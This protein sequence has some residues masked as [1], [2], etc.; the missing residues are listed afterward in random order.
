[1]KSTPMSFTPGTRTAKKEEQ[2]A[3]RAEGDISSLSASRRMQSIQALSEKS[4]GKDEWVVSKSSE[5]LIHFS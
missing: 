4:E 3:E 2:P 5:K 1:M